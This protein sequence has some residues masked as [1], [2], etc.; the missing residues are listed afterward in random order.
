VADYRRDWI[1]E[2]F[3]D[4][5]W[6]RCAQSHVWELNAD[7]HSQKDELA[8]RYPDRTYAVTRLAFSGRDAG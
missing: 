5:R 3:V 2:E 7:A 1:V 8:A 6:V 4:G